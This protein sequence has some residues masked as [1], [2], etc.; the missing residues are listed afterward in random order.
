MK[1]ILIRVDGDHHIGTG[2]VMR[3]LALAQAWQRRGGAVVFCCVLL[4][5]ALQEKLVAGG[6]EVIYQEV[7]PGGIDDAEAVVRIAK[8]REVAAIVCDNYHFTLPFQKIVSAAGARF[9][10]VVDCPVTEPFDCDFILN[11]N[12]G[13]ACDDYPAVTIATKMLIGPTFALLRQEFLERRADLFSKEESPRGRSRILVTFGGADPHNTT[14]KVIGILGMVADAEGWEVKV[15]VGGA[16][17]HLAEIERLAVAYSSIELLCDVT[18]MPELMAWCDLVISAAGSTV[19]ELCLFGIPMV[20]ISI[21]DNQDGIIKAM[22]AT[23]AAI[24]LGAES[25]LEPLALERATRELL[26]DTERRDEVSS[27]ARSLVD[28]AG[29]DRVAAALD[30]NLRVT[31]ITS[32]KGWVKEMLSDFVDRLRTSGHMVTIVYEANEI[33]EC[34]ISLFLSFWSLVPPEILARS[35]HNLVVHASDLPLGKGWSPMTWQIIEGEDVIPITLFEAQATVDSG[36]IY[37]TDSIEFAGHELLHEMRVA[38]MNKSYQLCERFIE[39]YP[40]IAVSGKMQSGEESFYRRRGPSDSQLEV[41]QSLASQFN[42]L[43]T[44]D[45]NL[46]PAFFDYRGCR[47]KLRIEKSDEG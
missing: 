19:W 45:N 43:R 32:S 40:E 13:S 5:N 39:N 16:N 28:G 44:V 9:L 10:V 30:S 41:D 26:S 12:A 15:V 29:A 3:M 7:D 20:L 27:W 38:L 37:C 21:A 31:V 14:A 35:T 18:D 36:R 6:F 47:Y 22:D 46:Y 1:T 2:H 23:G 33:P 24:N 4:P 42:L 8:A 17:P 11:Q 25:E 34:D